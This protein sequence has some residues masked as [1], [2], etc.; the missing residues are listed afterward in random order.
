MLGKQLVSFEMTESLEGE[1]KGEELNGPDHSRLVSARI[2]DLGIC[3]G[4]VYLLKWLVRLASYVWI[5]RRLFDI[6][7]IS[8]H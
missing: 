1:L 7:A 6:L 2:P 4:V 3:L 5:S 8:Q